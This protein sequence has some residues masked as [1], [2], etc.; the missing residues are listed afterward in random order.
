MARSAGVRLAGLG[1]AYTGGP[2]FHDLTLDVVPGT[3]V[4]LTGP[5]GVGKSTLL[6]IVAGIE[7]AE[8]V[9]QV[10]GRPAGR[11]PAPGMVFQDPRLLPWLG[12]RA[13]LMA[14]APGLDAEGAEALLAEVGLAGQGEARP[15]ALSGGMQRRVALAR[16]MAARPGLLLLD[17]PFVSLDADLATGM[18]ALLLRLIA[19]D[20][21]TVL[22]V[23]H[24]GIDAATLAD[25]IVRLEGRPARIVGDLVPD[26]PPAAR[27]AADIAGIARRI[28]PRDDG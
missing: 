13:N 19:R 14:V 3:V 2:L 26:V 8:G 18:R 4:A 9:V 21:P 6:R 5:S 23:T 28:A 7:P 11:A 16:A 25:R 12:A 22:L 1:K 15:G 17:E 24:D 20:R 27:G 10:G